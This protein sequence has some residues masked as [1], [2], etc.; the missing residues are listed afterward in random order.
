MRGRLTCRCQGPLVLVVAAATA[1]QELSLQSAFGGP[2]LLEELRP[3]AGTL[4]VLNIDSVFLNVSTFIGDLTLTS[5]ASQSTG[6]SLKGHLS[7]KLLSRVIEAMSVQPL[8]SRQAPQCSLLSNL[9]S[10]DELKG[11]NM[12]TSVVPVLRR[13]IG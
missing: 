8:L 1:V 4:K 10:L 6:G 9:P 3:M 5:L 12:P 2:R 13:W 11:C 7:S